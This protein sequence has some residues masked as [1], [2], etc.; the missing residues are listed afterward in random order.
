MTPG[1]TFAPTQATDPLEQQSAGAALGPAQRALQVLSFQLPR[2]LGS[3]AISP[4]SLLA[5]PDMPT[6]PGSPESAVLQTMLRTFG[7][8][9]G[10]APTHAGAIGGGL[11]PTPGGPG[12]MAFDLGG[13]ENS[14]EQILAQIFRNLGTVTGPRITPGQTIPPIGPP[15]VSPPP[16]APIAPAHPPFERRMIGGFEA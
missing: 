13:G 14:L 4:Q 15:P 7:Q 6:G 5:P 10:Q 12:P 16:A 3:R 9:G 8:M 2:F 1:L 11:P